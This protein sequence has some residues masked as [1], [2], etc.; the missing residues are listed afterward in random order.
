MTGSGIDRPLDVQRAEFARRRFLAMPLAGTLAWSVVGV[1]GLVLPDRT[2]VLVLF[3]ATGMIAYLGM[4]LSKFTGE[5]FLD[6][7]RP[8]N[9][10]DA[11]FFQTVGMSL[12]V[13][14]IAIPFFMA[15]HTSLPLSVG[16]LSGLMW[17]PMS[18]LLQHWVG[19]AHAAAR[20]VAVTAAWFLFPASRFVAIPVVI[21]ALYLAVIAVLEARWRRLSGAD[22][23]A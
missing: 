20:T 15:D 9:T 2:T 5:H 14:A 17:L 16:V 6:R 4:F 21:V 12:L 10:F 18:W 19:I 23:L 22:A 7:T 13:Y 3:V 8:K 1:S 11:L